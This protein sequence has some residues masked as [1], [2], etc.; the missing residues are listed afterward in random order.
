MIRMN[1]FLDV[2][3]LFSFTF[4]DLCN[5]PLLPDPRLD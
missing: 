2:A 4:W 1:W 3:H 5:L